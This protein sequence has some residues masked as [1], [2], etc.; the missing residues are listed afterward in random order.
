MWQ[1]YK[2]SMKNYD[3]ETKSFRK[4]SQNT[5]NAFLSNENAETVP[6]RPYFVNKR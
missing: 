1:N 3:M 4:C 2:K 5:K 6:K